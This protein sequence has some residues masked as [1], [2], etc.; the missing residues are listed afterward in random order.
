MKRKMERIRESLYIKNLGPVKEV[1]LEDITPMTVLIG[2][3]GC[4]KS[5]VMK[6]LSICRWVNKMVYLRQY[7]QMG[8]IKE[9]PFKFDFR[10]Y[11]K[12]SS[13]PLS[14]DTL[15]KY[16]FDGTIILFDE[17][18]L[19]INYSESG[20]LSLE[21]ICFITEKRN[22]ISD[23][24]SLRANRK[25]AGFYLNEILDDFVL[26]MRN[27]ETIDLDYLGVRLRHTNSK[28]A[29][30]Y[31]VVGI[32][33]EN[34]QFDIR[35][36][37]ASSGI[38]TVLPLVAVMSY[39][40]DKFDIVKRF[41]QSIF[42]MLSETDSLKDFRPQMN[43]GEIPH[44]RV[45]FL[46]EEPEL[47]LDPDSQTHLIDFMVGR[48]FSKKS[49]GLSDYTVMLATHSPYIVNYL[50]LLIARSKKG[51]DGGV[52]YNDVNAYYMDKGR[53]YTLRIGDGHDIIDASSMSTT[54]SNIYAE[55]N[56]LSDGAVAEK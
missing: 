34:E 35:L 36:N 16:E 4:G 8:N 24:V 26:A 23:L 5:T 44:R 12:T 6:V 22:M 41:N 32:G 19:R 50:N 46:I 1:M 31:H 10:S 18:G 40:T 54:I 28:G 43:I 33:E 48:C 45:N 37:E 9:S 47:S 17:G 49:D 53:C 52:S 25:D 51:L 38:Q 11:F 2:K 14:A 20:F 39:Y 21:K 7:L 15:I 27:Y 3:S 55:Y 13:V 29:D 56:Y 30:A 42:R